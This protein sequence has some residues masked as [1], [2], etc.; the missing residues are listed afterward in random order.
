MTSE[1]GVE[2]ARA[3]STLRQLAR[4]RAGVERCELCGLDLAADHQHL[5]EP[6]TRR[7]L[8]AC[9]ACA[10]LFDAGAGS[11]V[12]VSSN[13][14]DGAPLHGASAVVMHSADPNGADPGAAAAAN[15][16]GPSLAVDAKRAP[17]PRRYRRVP[18]DV[19][20]LPD[21][22]ITEAQWDS[23]RVPIEMVFFFDSSVAGRIVALYPSPAGPTES[24]LGLET[25][26]EI[27][28]DH[29]TVRGMHADVE[30]LLANRVGTVRRG[31]RG[32]YFV[33][34]ID[35]CFKLVGVIR[36][37][38]KGL[39]GGTTVWKEIEQFFDS[40]RQRARPPREASH[41]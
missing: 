40:I 13:G 26:N 30:A 24:L 15:G 1:T 2:Q 21:F 23:L 28:K 35:E 8:C 31:G 19:W 38:W 17:G 22:D 14:A 20:A 12:G 33:V 9:D 25:W 10:V 3:F 27:V 36:T 11:A 4:R 5:I 16:A 6:P 7:L 32:E 41:A 34:P 39:S 29:P 37:H 18:R